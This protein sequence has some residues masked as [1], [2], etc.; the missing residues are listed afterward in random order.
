M[1]ADYEYKNTVKKY[2]EDI[3]NYVSKKLLVQ[4]KQLLLLIIKR[5]GLS[6]I[7]HH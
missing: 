3:P 5:Y 2:L 4:M 1:Y 7:Y 6:A